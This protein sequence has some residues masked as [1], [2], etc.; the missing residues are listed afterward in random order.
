MNY[1]T[2]YCPGCYQDLR[3]CGCNPPCPCRPHCRPPRCDFGCGQTNELLF[4]AIGYL[5]AKNCK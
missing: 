5:F 2:R 3:P 1:T 4:F